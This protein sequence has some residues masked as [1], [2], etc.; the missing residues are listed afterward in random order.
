MSAPTTAAPRIRRDLRFEHSVSPQDVKNQ[1]TGEV[2]YDLPIGAGRA[3]NLHGAANAVLGGWTANTIVYLSTGIPIPSPGTGTPIGY[4]NQRAD[5][6][7]QSR[8]WRAAHR[9]HLD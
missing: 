7:L 4:F 3:V 9:C 6:T 2:S 8:P 5:M 1:F